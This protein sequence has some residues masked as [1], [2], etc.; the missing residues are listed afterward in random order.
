MTPRRESAT[1]KFEHRLA[2]R[3]QVRYM[4]HL[5]VAGMTARSTDA[6]A[7][8][9][10]V[11]EQRL[12]GRYELEVIDIYLEPWLACSDQIIVAPTLVRRWPLPLRRLVGDLSSWK[13]L[14]IGLDL[15]PLSA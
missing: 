15:G 13:R 6:I 10:E 9:K 4:L 3:D 14:L 11:C 5:Y 7:A 1:P 8:I 12:Q 2:E